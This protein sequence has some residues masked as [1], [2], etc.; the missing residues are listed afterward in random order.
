MVTIPQDCLHE[1]DNIMQKWSKDIDGVYMPKKFLTMQ[2]KINNWE[3]NESDVWIVSFPKTGTTW[4]QEMV[5]L[6]LNDLDYKRAEKNLLKRSPQLEAAALVRYPHVKFFLP[7]IPR[8]ITDSLNYVKKQQS[9]VCIKTHLPWNLLPKEI[10]KDI[11]RPKI[12]YISRNPKDTCVSYYHFCRLVKDFDG[13]LEEF[14]NL[15]LYGK[16]NFAPYWDHILPFWKRRNQQNVLFLKYEEL[17]ENLPSVIERVAAFLGKK[18]NA[19]QINKLAD[20]LSFE[21]MKNNK[22]VNYDWLVKLSSIYK[23]DKANTFM[24]VG[25]V[26][27]YKSAMSEEMIER[28]DRWTREHTKDIDLEF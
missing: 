16:V 3:V 17:K 1:M 5:W 24:R 15:F 19:D 22:A 13:T 27:G 20:H 28:F 25:K 4:T 23:P 14:C 10:Q 11:K 6:I 18:L 12:I 21:N 2:D 8:A 26:G 7:F 9:P